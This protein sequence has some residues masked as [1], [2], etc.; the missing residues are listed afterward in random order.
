MFCVL[1]VFTFNLYLYVCVY[2]CIF[3]TYILWVF[4]RTLESI[5]MVRDVVCLFVFSLLVGFLDCFGVS[6][7]MDEVKKC[8]IP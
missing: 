3:V 7:F 2:A 6:L 4:S 5:S 1:Y 8:D